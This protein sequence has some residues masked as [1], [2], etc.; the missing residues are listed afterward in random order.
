MPWTCDKDGGAVI[1]AI[2]VDGSDAC[3]CDTC[4]KRALVQG[5]IGTADAGASG[6]ADAIRY[7]NVDEWNDIA[8]AHRIVDLYRQAFVRIADD[9]RQAVGDRPLVVKH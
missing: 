7:L 2:T 1:D 4:R 8:Q 9:L 3:G 6:L 5:V